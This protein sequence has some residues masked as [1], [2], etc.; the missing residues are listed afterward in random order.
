[1]SKLFSCDYFTSRQNVEKRPITD[2]EASIKKKNR[3]F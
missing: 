3:E 1:M 2:S